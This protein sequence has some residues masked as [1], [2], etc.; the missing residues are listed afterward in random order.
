MDRWNDQVTLG[1]RA[2]DAS[3]APRVRFRADAKLKRPSTC[4]VR[5]SVTGGVVSAYLTYDVKRLRFR[6]LFSQPA[7]TKMRGGV[8]SSSLYFAQVSLLLLYSLASFYPFA[9]PAHCVA[10]SLLMRRAE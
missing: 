5:S 4:L 7:L 6:L 1:C 3:C 8:L 10:R 2:L 9:Y